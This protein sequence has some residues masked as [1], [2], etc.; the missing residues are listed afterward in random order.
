MSHDTIPFF[1]Y[2]ASAVLLA[3]VGLMV[4]HDTSYHTVRKHRKHS[5][6]PQK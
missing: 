5:H 1:L 4:W 6:L 3:I 2:A